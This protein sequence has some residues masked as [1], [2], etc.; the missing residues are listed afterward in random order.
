MRELKKLE[1]TTIINK[2]IFVEVETSMR[3]GIVMTMGS[4]GRSSA[5]VALRR[6]KML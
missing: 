1:K 2:R 4:K 5:D 3:E 6:K